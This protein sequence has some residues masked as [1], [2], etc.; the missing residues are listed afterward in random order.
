M[1][2][3]VVM[4]STRARTAKK[5][6]SYQG[7]ALAGSVSE[8]TTRAAVKSAALVFEFVS[9]VVS[10]LE[11]GLTIMRNSFLALV[12]GA[13][14][15]ATSFAANAQGVYSGG[16]AAQAGQ[17]T[18]TRGASARIKPVDLRER[19]DVDPRGVRAGSFIVF[20]Q[21]ALEEVFTDNLFFS[22]GGRQSDFITKIRPEIDVRSDWNNH[23]LNFLMYSDIGFHASHSAE[24]YID[25]TLE[26]NGRLDITRE[27]NITAF[28]RYQAGHEERS[29]PDDANGVEPGEFVR[30]EGDLGFNHKFNRVG[31]AFLSNVIRLDYDD[32][33]TSTG[34]TVNNDDRDRTVLNNSLRVNYEL[35]PEVQAYVRGVYHIR[36]YDDGVDDNG[37]DRD[38]AGY[39]AVGGTDLDLGGVL[40][41]T[42]F[43]GW[44]E[45]DYDDPTLE[46][47]T[48]P[49]WG[50]GMTWNPTLLT[51]YRARIRRQVLETTQNNASGYFSTSY[52]ISADH[53][54]RR[55]V[56]LRADA[57]ATFD[58]YQGNGRSD[59]NYAINTRARWLMNRHLYLTAQYSWEQK[60]TNAAGAG[61]TANTIFF[62]LE[63]QL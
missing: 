22:Q 41:G 44:R 30:L 51:T 50:L 33:R 2:T 56:L 6:S 34:T 25:Y 60:I 58:E 4:T 57:R 26:T 13:A 8:I 39:T 54:L 43:A 12:S 36:E 61:F 20:P 59:D 7:G 35:T 3:K 31:T 52:S 15:V 14:I 17:G 55:N 37:E 19:P 16:S 18:N 49:T 1:I 45:Q 11:Q 32:V 23:A 47:I 40:V 38:S 46:T 63:T 27:T 24:D 62:R 48:G 21:V 10:R 53:E 42:V 29:S 5:L 28:G 9:R